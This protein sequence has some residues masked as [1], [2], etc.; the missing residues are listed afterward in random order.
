MTERITEDLVRSHFKSDPIFDQVAL[1]EQ[2]SSK[3]RIQKLFSAASKSG[4]GKPG[5]PEFIMTFPAKK[6]VLI[7]VE[8]KLEHKSHESPTR[9]KPGGFAVD[10][11]LHYMQAANAIDD[12]FDI[13]GIAVSGARPRDLEVSHFHSP[14]G[15]SAFSETGDNKLLSIYSYLKIHQN[16]EFAKELGTIHIQEKAQEYNR[17]LHQYEIPE[18]ERCTF[19]SAVLVALQDDFF[20]SSY[21][22]SKNVTELVDEMIAACKRVL[23]VNGITEGRRKLSC[24]NTKE[25]EG[26]R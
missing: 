21:K 26:I 16:A 5:F 25:S 2:K 22:Y 11:V 10:G 18:H 3:E 14:A 13:I 4:S 24:T 17:I 12:T 7:I 1:E 23:E 19:I 15:T 9:D 8:C 6:N 20:R